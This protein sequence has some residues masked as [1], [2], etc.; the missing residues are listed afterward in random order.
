MTSATSDLTQAT[1]DFIRHSQNHLDKV[2]NMNN[3]SAPDPSWGETSTFLKDLKETQNELHTGIHDNIEFAV[4]Y[5]SPVK[6]KKSEATKKKVQANAKAKSKPLELNAIAHPL[7]QTDKKDQPNQSDGE[8]SGTIPPLNETEVT[9]TLS[10]ANLYSNN[11][12]KGTP[13]DH[14]KLDFDIKSLCSK[15]CW[16]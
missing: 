14:D 3:N 11:N 8:F 10:T 7:E 9:A 15:V 16:V 2:P 1:L 12:F 5:Y 13:A 4:K 6:I